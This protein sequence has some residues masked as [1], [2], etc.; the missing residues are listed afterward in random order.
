M[1]KDIIIKCFK[2]PNN[3]Y[4][5]D[6]QT[7]SIVCVMD[8]DF[9]E[10]CSLSVNEITASQCNCLK[11]Y[12]DRGVFLPNTVKTV[13]HLKTDDLS[14][15]MDNDLSQLILQVTQQCNLRCGYCA[16]SGIYEGHRVHQNK[17]M[18]FELAKRGIDFFIKHSREKDSIDIGFYGGEPLLEFDLLRK[19]TEYAKGLVEGKEL[20]FGLTT[21]GTLLKD[22]IA[23]YLVKNDFRIGI[24]LDGPKREHDINRRFANGKGSFDTIIQNVK[25]LKRNYPEFV[26]NK[27]IFMTVIN[28]KSDLGCVTEYFSEDHLMKDSNIMFSSM[29]ETSA[30]VVID[31]RRESLILRRYEYLKLM[32]YLIRRMDKKYVSV[33]ERDSRAQYSRNYELFRRHTP[34]N[35]EAHPGG[36]CLPG[37][38][39]L[40]I[41][42]EGDFYPCERVSEVNTYFKIGSIDTGFDLKSMKN[43]LNNAKISEQTCKTCWALP[44]CKICSNDIEF[45]EGNKLCLCEK[46]KA[47]K[48]EKIKIMS[49]IY[50]I[51]VL[52]EFGYQD[53]NWS[54]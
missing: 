54:E 43:V 35:A 49:D 48:S 2:T 18:S 53:E 28:P 29:R 9:K 15:M 26:K 42:T 44:A 14:H 50:E 40:F 12:Q 4:V 13:K 6:R 33:L 20:T 21:N 47:C 23:E 30:K 39:R 37:I 24:S 32:F 34:L 8:K 46:L 52:R 3:N 22:E 36:P 1:T 10:L 17:R 51:C 45:G 38:N 11:S 5:Y 25:S 16:Y 31:Y 27:I 19:C 7:N 41:T